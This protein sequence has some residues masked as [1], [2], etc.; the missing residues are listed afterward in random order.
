MSLKEI[1][2]PNVISL[3][4]PHSAGYRHPVV[5]KNET[6]KLIFKD[7]RCTVDRSVESAEFCA[8]VEKLAKLDS[9]PFFILD[10]FESTL[11]Q[12]SVKVKLANGKIYE[13]PQ[14]EIIKL[15]EAKIAE[16]TKEK[17]NGK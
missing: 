9:V 14:E 13:V 6:K 11:L 1:T 12:G 4:C 17:T 2:K 7:N 15:A 8:E 10:E 5:T 16:K 3:I